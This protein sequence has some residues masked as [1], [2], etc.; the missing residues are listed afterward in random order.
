MQYSFW[1]FVGLVQQSH[2]LV[3]GSTQLSQ[4]HGHTVPCPFPHSLFT[5][6]FDHCETLL[7]NG[8]L[9]PYV[10]MMCINLFSV[11]AVLSIWIV[12]YS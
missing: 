10:A 3:F 12:L 6:S 5:R 9:I 8:V 4:C 7:N 1:N 11:F 2:M